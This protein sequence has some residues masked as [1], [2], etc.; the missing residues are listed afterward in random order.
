MTQVFISWSGHHSRKIAETLRDWIPSVLQFARP[1]F[2][3]NDI[4]KGTK[5]NSEISKCLSSSDIG[6]ICLTPKNLLSPWILFEAGALSKNM[7]ESRVSAILFKLDAADVDGP[8]ASF[9]NT[10]FNKEDFRKLVGTINSA[11]G[12][13]KL[14]KDVLDRVFDKWWPELQADILAI[15]EDDVENDNEVRND[16]SLLEEV[17]ELTRLIASKTTPKHRHPLIPRVAMNDL[18]KSLNTIASFIDENPTLSD[19]DEEH[20][21]EEAKFRLGRATRYISRKHYD[22]LDEKGDS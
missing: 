4:E 2:T 16:R 13:S 3:P 12:S 7:D 17:V 15:L 6:I 11:G 8:L 9:Q 5:W 10:V 1:Y 20:P 18:E 22:H 19:G 21:L 14:E